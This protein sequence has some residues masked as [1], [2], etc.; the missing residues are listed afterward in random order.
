MLRKLK[1]GGRMNITCII[2]GV[3]FIALGIVFFVGKAHDHIESYRRMSEAERAD[4]KIEPLC[5]NVGIVV[6][7]AGI[8]FLIAGL[9]PMFA[10]KGFIWYMITWFIGA[11]FDVRFISKSNHYKNNA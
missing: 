10:S 1:G 5:R 4:I 3:L 7:L 11:G 6:G 9:F 2:F 8:G